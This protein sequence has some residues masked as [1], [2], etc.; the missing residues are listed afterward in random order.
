MSTVLTRKDLLIHFLD[1]LVNPRTEL[2]ALV[3]TERTTKQILARLRKVCSR[4]GTV[5]LGT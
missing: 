2:D 3:V 1:I 4:A 5:D